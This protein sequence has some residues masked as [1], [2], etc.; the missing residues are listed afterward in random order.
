MNGQALWNITYNPFSGYYSRFLGIMGNND[1][2]YTNL[3][4]S[5]YSEASQILTKWSSEGD[6]IWNHTHTI[7]NSYGNELNGEIWVVEDNY[8]T[9]LEISG[10][11]LTFTPYRYSP[12]LRKWDAEGNL[13]WEQVD[14]PSQYYREATI[15][16]VSTIWS[17]GTGIYV[18]T[19]QKINDLETEFLLIHYDENGTKLWENSWNWHGHT[20][21]A[22][23]I[24]LWGDNH[25][26]YSAGQIYDLETPIYDGVLNYLIKWSVPHKVNLPLIIGLSTG[27]F[28][29]VIAILWLLIKRFRY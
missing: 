24:S 27:G 22:H 3:I 7:E 18:G 14:V 9:L 10:Q 15:P 16:L 25:S 17:N 26:I 8:Y 5:T 23:T 2:I 13:L 29:I 21:H 4:R 19:D 12:I 6:C 1:S 28:I 20:I 11:T